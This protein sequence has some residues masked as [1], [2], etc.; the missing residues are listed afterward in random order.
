MLRRRYSVNERAAGQ[1]LL[2]VRAALRLIDD[3]LDGR[4]HLVGDG[5]TVADLTAAALLAPL[6]SPPQLPYRDPSLFPPPLTAIADELRMLPAG[7]WVL[8]TYASYRP[9]STEVGHGQE[10]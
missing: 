8:R 4:D 6:L 7:Q 9:A 2:K 5:F 10:R 3:R 1:S